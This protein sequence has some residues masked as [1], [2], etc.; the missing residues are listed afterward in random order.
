MTALR[1]RMT[2]DMQL[3]NL[4]RHTIRGYVDAVARFTKHF[5]ASPEKLGVEHVRPYRLHGNN[6]RRRQRD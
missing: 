5:N 2:E 4:S 6:Q 3:R 1:Q